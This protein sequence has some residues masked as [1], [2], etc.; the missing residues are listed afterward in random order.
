VIDFMFQGSAAALL[1]N[2]FKPVPLD[3]VDFTANH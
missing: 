2:Y 3:K 1:I